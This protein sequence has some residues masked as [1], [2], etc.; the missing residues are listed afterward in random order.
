[1]PGFTSPAAGP[2][3]WLSRQAVLGKPYTASEWQY[4]WPN[5]YRLEGVPLVAAHAAFQGWDAALQFNYSGADWAPIIDG[6]FDVGN[7]PEEWAQ[8]PDSSQASWSVIASG[9]SALSG[10]SARRSK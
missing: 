5:E 3:S 1:M 6:N 9:T 7:K 4:A 10:P 2:A 8:W